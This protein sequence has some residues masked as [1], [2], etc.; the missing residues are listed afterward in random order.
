MAEISEIIIRGPYRLDLDPSGNLGIFLNGTEVA[1]FDSS[2]NLH[3]LQALD[4]SGAATLSGN[5]S[6]GGTL[7]V[8]GATTLSN[9][10]SVSGAATF[11]STIN[12]NASQ[13]TLSG[14]TAG[15]VVY[16]EPFT[17]SSYKKVVLFFNGYENDTTT[18][19]TITYPTAFSTVA[20]ITFNNTGLTLS[21]STTTLTITSPDSTTTYTGLAIVEG[22]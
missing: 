9:T 22:Y 21:T 20:A 4:L 12:P 2:G 10:L 16:S 19:Q 17:G 8:S 7:S 3:Q 5:A 14:A 15:S 13:S 6:I 18:N 1:Y 11:S